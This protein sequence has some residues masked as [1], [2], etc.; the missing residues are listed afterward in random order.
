M[1][2]LCCKGAF[3][4][5]ST[6]PLRGKSHCKSILSSYNWSSSGSGL[7]LFDPALIHR[8]VTESLWSHGMVWWGWKCWKSDPTAII[9]SMVMNCD[10]TKYGD[11][12]KTPAEGK[13]S[14]QY[15]YRDLYNHTKVHGRCYKGLCPPTSCP[16]DRDLWRKSIC[17]SLLPRH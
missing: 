14:L 15:S 12:T 5:G 4:F 11:V 17:T 6:H 10:V 9:V 3:I 1:A 13:R 8:S 2:L 7:S 16:F